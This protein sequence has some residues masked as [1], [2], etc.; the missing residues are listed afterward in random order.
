[1]NE[2]I[3]DEKRANIELS[4][5][6]TILKRILLNSSP[7]PEKEDAKESE[8]VEQKEKIETIP[9]ESSQ[10]EPAV[11]EESEKENPVSEDPKEKKRGFFAKLLKRKPSN[12]VE[13][14]EVSIPSDEK[15]GFLARFLKKK[16][17]E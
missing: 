1:L 15:R 2:E 14:D 3:A 17:A 6:M 13:K 9:S 5:D 12:V 7:A 11:V 16:S 8:V 4:E 10:E